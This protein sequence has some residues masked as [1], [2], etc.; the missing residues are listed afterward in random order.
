[1]VLSELHMI[2]NGL[3]KNKKTVIICLDM[4]KA[5]LEETK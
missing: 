3:E 1:M 4:K 2:R 5:L